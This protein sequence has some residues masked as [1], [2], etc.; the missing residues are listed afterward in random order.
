M[1]GRFLKIRKLPGSFEMSESLQVVVTVQWDS[2][3]NAAFLSPESESSWPGC[4]TY[5]NL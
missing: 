2:G 4:S 3:G 1:D 5:S